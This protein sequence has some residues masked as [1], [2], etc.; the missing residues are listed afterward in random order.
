MAQDVLRR[1]PENRDAWGLLRGFIEDPR[2]PLARRAEADCGASTA[3]DPSLTSLAATS[4][5]ASAIAGS[6]TAGS[7]Q[8]Q[9][10]DACSGHAS[11]AAAQPAATA[12]CAASARRAA[13]TTPAIMAAS[14]SSPTS[15]TPPRSELERVGVANRLGDR[16]LLQPA[17]AEATGADAVQRRCSNALERATRQYS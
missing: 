11:S 13:I 10:I 15:P 6:A 5:A 7:C 14:A 12:G 17:D 4:A 3:R 1:E 16:A 9:S 2:S 8:S